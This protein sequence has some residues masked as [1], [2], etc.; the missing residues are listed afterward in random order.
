[1]LHCL[2]AYRGLEIS[3]AV[4]EGPRS[5]VFPQAENRLHFQKGLLA[6]LMESSNG[7]RDP[8]GSA[9]NSLARSRDTV[10]AIRGMARLKVDPFP[11][12]DFTPSSA[13]SRSAATDAT[14]SP[15]P[16]PFSP[17]VRPR[18]KAWKMAFILLDGIPGPS[19]DT[20]S[21]CHAPFSS[22]RDSHLIRTV[23]VVLYLTAL[24]TRFCRTS[25]TNS[26]SLWTLSPSAISTASVRPLVSACARPA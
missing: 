26:R 5:L 25:A 17:W 4:M 23:P 13:P 12:F 14:A 11:T 21:T 1:M 19:S 24:P 15:S 8:A 2:P 18:W 3:D 16:M 6:V 7:L 9:L 22:C 20:D 10:H